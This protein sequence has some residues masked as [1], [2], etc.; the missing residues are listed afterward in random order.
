M[1][2]SSTPRRALVVIDVQNEYFPG[3]NL[4]I[5]HPPVADTLPN[6]A[7][8]MDAAHAAGLPVVVVQHTAPAGSPV[9][10]KATDRWQLHPEVARRPADHRIEKTLASVFAGTDLADWLSARGIDTLTVVGYMTH[11]CDASTIFEA[12]HRG[13]EVEFLSDASGALPYANAA[14][15]VSAEEI[16]R[17]FSV[18]FH[19]NFA[20]VAPTSDWVAAVQAGK[21]LPK[22]NVFSSNQRGRQAA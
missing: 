8:A 13:L 2:A 17:V 14:G 3:G 19:S 11:N 21:A 5:E 1:T 18:V 6:I 9:F 12:A 22:D 15:R 20:A 16:H 10:D 7:R 4:P